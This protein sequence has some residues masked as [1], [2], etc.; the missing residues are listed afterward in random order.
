M[1]NIKA[2]GRKFLGVDHGDKRIGLALSDETL[3]FA[4]PLRII[5]HISRAE[6]AKRVIE[7]AHVESCTNILVG[8]PYDSDGNEGPRARTVLRFVEMLKSLTTLQVDVWDESGSTMALK[9]LS[10]QM[11]QS[12]KQRRKPSDDRV[13]ALILQD[14]LDNHYLAKDKND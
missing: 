3:R 1:T 13:A 5:E 7:I 8:V 11:G 12:A 6:D 14:Y 10:V 4:R 2:T 9:N